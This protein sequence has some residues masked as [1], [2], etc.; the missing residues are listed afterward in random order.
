MGGVLMM[1]NTE[2]MFLDL[3]VLIMCI[4]TIAILLIT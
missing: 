3:F 4:Y 1:D 2:D